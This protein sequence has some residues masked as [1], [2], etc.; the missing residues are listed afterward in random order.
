MGRFR[1]AAFGVGVTVAVFTYLALPLLR[2]LYGP[3]VNLPVYAVVALTAGVCTYSLVRTVQAFAAADREA[4]SRDLDVGE[5]SGD[6]ETA[7]D[8]DRPKPDVDRELEQIKEDSGRSG[9]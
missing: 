3:V 5:P 9:E 8:E 1:A 4:P 2:E 7:D 6:G